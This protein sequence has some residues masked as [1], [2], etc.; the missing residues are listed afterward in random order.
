[1]QDVALGSDL[2][3]PHDNW[4]FPV[5]PFP[6]CGFHQGSWRERQEEAS[7]GK[8]CHG[9]RGRPRRVDEGDAAEVLGQPHYCMDRCFSS[10]TS[11]VILQ[12][13]TSGGKLQSEAV[14]LK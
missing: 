3:I 6:Q 12:S 5:P 10:I 1:M 13:S 11:A 14:L 4:A 2:S 9:E 7:E 8:E